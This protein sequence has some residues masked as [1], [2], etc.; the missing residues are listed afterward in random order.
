MDLSHGQIALIT[1]FLVLTAALAFNLGDITG[2]VVAETDQ[3]LIKV[4]PALVKA[5]GDAKINIYPSDEGSSGKVEF[6]KD[7]NKI[8]ESTMLCG[9]RRC[10]DNTLLVY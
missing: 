10:Y 8:G 3:T 6:F 4:S 5:G 2:S 9:E 1:V 7:G